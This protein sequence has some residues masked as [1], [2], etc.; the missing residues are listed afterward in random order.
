MKLYGAGGHAKVIIDILNASSK[1]ITKIFDDNEIITNL[2]GI[3]VSLPDFFDD[4]EF[5]ISIGNN[6]IRKLVS[7]KMQ[8]A[9]FGIAI[10]PS[11]IISPYA[12]IGEG[13]VIMQGAIIQSA[14]KIGR[15]CII[16][17]GASVGHDCTI[18]DF[19]HISPKVALCGNVTVGE[20]THIGVGS[21]IVPGIN[22]GSWSLV[23]AGSVVTRNLPDRCVAGGNFCEIK[24]KNTG[25]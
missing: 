20:G 12:E 4:D 17:T 8:H 24:R 19:V 13:S 9:K 22:I 6:H 11:A 25:F 15:H 18:G 23:Y 10:H 7:K 2:H 3:C 16:N 21:S 1:K 14:A 5:I